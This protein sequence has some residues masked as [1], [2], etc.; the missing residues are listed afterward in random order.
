MS[1]KPKTG[2]RR[3]STG[4]AINFFR[5]DILVN[6]QRDL[7]RLE[8]AGIDEPTC[9]RI[10]GLL[11]ALVGAAATNKNASFWGTAVYDVLQEYEWTYRR[12][13][14]VKGSDVIAVQT[15]AELL[16]DLRNIRDKISKACRNSSR[17]LSEASD[18]D[19]IAAVSNA[20][21]GVTKNHSAEFSALKKSADR[22]SRRMN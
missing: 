13:N 1:T 5:S 18:L 4:Y 3:G 10:R 14:D 19:L 8:D 21:A 20:L 2:L 15:R 22:F 6:L 16:S 7:R 12:W 9:E 11:S 17:S